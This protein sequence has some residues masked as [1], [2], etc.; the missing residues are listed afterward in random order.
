MLVVECGLGPGIRS[1]E[2]VVLGRHSGG[3]PWD[4]SR[5]GAVRCSLS[6]LGVKLYLYECACNASAGGKWAR[7]KGRRR[8]HILL[9]NVAFIMQLSSGNCA[10]VLGSAEGISV[11]VLL[12]LWVPVLQLTVIYADDWQ[13]GGLR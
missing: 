8:R 12:C 1:K 7:M 4:R 10:W 2:G 5:F 13:L 3:L 9:G 6:A 11:C